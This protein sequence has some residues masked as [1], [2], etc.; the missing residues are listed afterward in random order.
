MD[1]STHAVSLG[2]LAAVP[3]APLVGAILAGFFGKVI[4]RKG[5]HTVCILGVLVAFA[6]SCG[7]FFAVRGGGRVDETLYTGHR[8]ATCASRSAS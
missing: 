2:I 1:P 3:L 5:A 8:S 7:V 4:G 6:L